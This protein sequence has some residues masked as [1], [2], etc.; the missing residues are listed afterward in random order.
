MGK[1]AVTGLFNG[2]KRSSEKRYI[3]PTSWSFRDDDGETHGYYDTDTMRSWLGAGYLASD[4]EVQRRV[5]AERGIEEFEWLGVVDELVSSGYTHEST[6]YYKV[7]E[8]GEEHG[9]FGLYI[10]RA[11]I[12]EEMLDYSSLLAKCHDAGILHEDKDEAWRTANV[13]D[14]FTLLCEIGGVFGGGGEEDEEG[15]EYIGEE[16]EEGEAGEEY[17]GGEEEEEEESVKS[18]FK[19]ATMQSV[20]FGFNRSDVDG[21]GTAADRNKKFFEKM[22]QEREEK[23]RHDQLEKEETLASM[24]EE[25]R[26]RFLIVEAADKKHSRD[27][28]RMLKKQMKGFG[29]GKNK[30]KIKK[31]GR[32]RTKKS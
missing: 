4:T 19:R 14:T 1:I 15:E 30:N 31:S 11:W 7:E 28:T 20:G 18:S 29:G 27:K 25:E 26:T 3:M 12:T 16:G 22:K 8:T 24:S 10:L 17:I 13:F 32:G 21:D 6:W 9:P 23:E 5:D 2:K